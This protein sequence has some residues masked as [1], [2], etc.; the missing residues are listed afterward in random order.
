MFYPVYKPKDN[1]KHHNFHPKNATVQCT[2][3][4]AIIPTLLISCVVSCMQ[5]KKMFLLFKKKINVKTKEKKTITN[6][7]H[8]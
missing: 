8:N 4:G 7:I 3:I 5:Y 6:K 2:D 1:N